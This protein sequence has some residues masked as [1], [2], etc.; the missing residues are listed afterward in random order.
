MQGSVILYREHLAEN[1]TLLAIDNPELFRGKEQCLRGPSTLRRSSCH[2]GR[3]S[4]PTD[5]TRRA[6]SG[7]HGPTTCRSIGQVAQTSNAVLKPFFWPPL[8][9]S[10]R[11]HRRPR[12]AGGGCRRRD[13]EPRRIERTHDG[14]SI[15]PTA[16]Q[17][18][19]GQTLLP[20]IRAASRRCPPRLLLPRNSA[21]ALLYVQ[22]GPMSEDSE[23]ARRDIEQLLYALRQDLLQERHP[24]PRASREN[25]TLLGSTH[26]LGATSGFRSLAGDAQSL[27]VSRA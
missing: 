14:T 8:A 10:R 17:V 15:P 22:G 12:V 4:A 13:T 5:R 3:R 1:A 16:I 19:K 25:A 24:L 7:R 18:R 6:T 26:D 2:A 20:A 21:I 23:R 11:G 27:G 9:I